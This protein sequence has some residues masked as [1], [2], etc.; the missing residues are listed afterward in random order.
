M[1]LSVPSAT[2]S[3]LD[4]CRS[5]SSRKNIPILAWFMWIL[6]G[7]IFYSLYDEFPLYVA[8]YKSTSVGWAIGWSLPVE[9][10]KSDDLVSMLF[11]SAHN[12]IG[13]VFVG[14]SA[15][16]IAREITNSKDDWTV[17]VTNRQSL[18]DL[19]VRSVCGRAQRWYLLHKVLVRLV[20]V[21]LGLILLCVGAGYSVRDYSLPQAL[22]MMLSTISCCGYLG[23]PEDG[24]PPA[25]YILLAGYT[26]VAVPV[27]AIALGECVV[28]NR[29]HCIVLC[30]I[31]LCCTVLYCIALYCVVL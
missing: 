1:P 3:L 18:R 19:E 29:Y 6:S 21:T 2:R 11:S 17:Q 30:C 22:D 15:I 8:I 31:V 10:R 14:L 28:I 25:M 26:N 16:Y 12:C 23:L 20:G 9:R 5:F 13:V 7:T 27:F 4:F 24:E